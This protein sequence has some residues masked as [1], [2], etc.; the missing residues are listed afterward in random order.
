MIGTDGA[1]KIHH[2]VHPIGG[3][4][5][6]EDAVYAFLNWPKSISAEP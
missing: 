2:L 1:L 3:E 5:P 6:G 4:T